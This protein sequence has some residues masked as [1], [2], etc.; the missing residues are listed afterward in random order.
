MSVEAVTETVPSTRVDVCIIGAGQAGLAVAHYLR[1]AGH[2]FQILEASESAGAAWR[3]RWDS[4][5]LFTSRRFDELPGMVFPG[6]PDGYPTRSEVVEYLQS[7]AAAF[8]FP[9]RFKSPV[10][11]LV[12]SEDGFVLGVPGGS[13][14]A[15]RV[16]VATGPFQRPS[17]PPIATELS[18]DLPQMHSADYRRPNDV[19]GGHVLVVG[20]GNTGF[21]IAKEL[22]TTRPVT[23][24][25]GSR[26]MPLPQRVL[27]HDLFWWLTKF[28]LL[29][30]SVDSRFGKRARSRETLI[31]SSSRE[32][33]RHGIAR[34]PRA[35]RA[36]GRTVTFADGTELDIDTV[37]WA[38][39]YRPDH[40]WIKL[41]IFG[42]DGSVNHRRGVTE[43]TGLYFIGLPWQHTRGSALLGFV[44]DDA[45]YIAEQI[46][47]ARAAHGNA[48]DTAKPHAKPLL[49][50]QVALDD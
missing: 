45:R 5:V 11:S 8:E 31:G 30:K 25:V 40:A 1:H 33:R 18:A 29:D 20:G 15:E 38:T 34:K 17:I 2:S 50:R 47:S 4:L 9:I 24:A 3:Q 35:I 10:S 36:E 48:N 12:R 21:Q 49:D 22:S 43:V 6:E 16:V 23:L 41:P 42:P 32:L 44:K 13:V 26:Q 28:G 27:G 39:G 14:T 46:E 37:I 19:A 7:Y